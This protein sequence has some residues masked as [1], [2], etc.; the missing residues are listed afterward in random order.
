MDSSYTV[1]SLNKQVAVLPIKRENT[2]DRPKAKG[3]DFTDV[4]VTKLVSSE[5]VFD[6][7]KFSAGDILYFKSDVLKLPYVNQKL[8]LEDRIFIMVPEEIVVLSKSNK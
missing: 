3:L 2:Q 4:T 8:Q 5:V 7:E 6:S 1:K